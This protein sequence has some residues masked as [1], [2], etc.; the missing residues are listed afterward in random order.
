MDSGKKIGIGVA[1]SV[2]VILVIFLIF[3]AETESD[4][5]R[6]ASI[7]AQYDTDTDRL[8]VSVFLTDSNAEF[9]KANGNAELIILQDGRVVYT[10]GYSFVKDDFVSWI[11]MFGDKNT[12]YVIVIN[13]FFPS[14]ESVIMEYEVRVNLITKAKN[15][16]GLYDKFWSINQSS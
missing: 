12:G 13:K 2:G 3:V 8:L 7:N 4:D 6:L 1:V 15:W 14:G 9:T 11:N 5:A 10:A 16:E